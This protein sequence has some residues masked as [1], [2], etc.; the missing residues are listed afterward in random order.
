MTCQE[1]IDVMGEAL[2]GRLPADL[3]P[4]FDEHMA[5]CPPCATYLQHLQV[6]RNAL[7]RLGAE[8]ASNPRHQ[9]LIDAFRR[10]FGRN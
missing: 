7:L 5:E 2:E 3:R 6:T 10:E 4:G 1:A 8:G 9:E